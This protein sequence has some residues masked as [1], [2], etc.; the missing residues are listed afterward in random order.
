MLYTQMSASKVIPALGEVP[1]GYELSAGHMSLTS[2]RLAPLDHSKPILTNFHR[3]DVEVVLKS[4]QRFD[5]LRFKVSQYAE[6]ETTPM[7][8][9]RT[10]T[11]WTS[12]D[13]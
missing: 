6:V 5:E 10:A 11:P 2:H 13:E 7:G 9:D 4:D 12:T 3:L 1:A 8:T